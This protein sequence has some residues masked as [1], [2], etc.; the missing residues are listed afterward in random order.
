MKILGKILVA[1]IVAALAVGV[2]IYGSKQEGSSLTEE[3]AESVIIN[4]F[5]ASNKSCIADETGD[6]ADWIEL[7]NP[8]DK[9]ID[10]TGISL[11]NKQDNEIGWVFPKVILEPKGY[12]VVFATSR[13]VSNPKA[14]FQHTGFKLSASGGEI[15]LMDGANVLDQVKYT[16]QT[17]NVSAGR[18]SEDIASWVSFKKPTPGFSN[19]EA[20]AAAFAQSRI[21]EE[22]A[23]LITEVM[24]SNSTTV[25]DGFGNFND[26]IEIYNK[27]EEAIDLGGYGL[28]D[29]EDNV[30]KWH[31]PQVVIEP[32]A[33][34]I[35]FASGENVQT[36]DGELH[37][38]F[39]VSSYKETIVLSNRYGMILDKLTVQELSSDHAYA[40]EM[41]AD[42]SY[43]DGWAETNQPTPGYPNNNTGYS[44]FEKNNVVA[45]GPIVINEI[46]ISNASLLTEEDGGNYDWIELYNRSNEIVDITGYS[47]T[48]DPDYPTKWR[49]PEKTL[50]PGEY[51]TV[52]ASGLADSDDVKKKYIHTNFKLSAMGEVLVLYD[53]NVKLQD[54]YN[55]PYL[56]QGITLGRVASE[57]PLFC[58]QDPTPN[59]ANAAPLTG[60]ITAP[61][62]SVAG[63]SYDT[64][65][66]VAFSTETPDTKVYY[67]LDGTEPT[68]NSTRYSGAISVNKTGVIRARAYRDG[69]IDSPINTVTYFIGEEHSLPLV[70][71]VADPDS[72]FNKVSGIYELGPDPELVQGSTIH[73]EKANYLERGKES[74]RPASFEVFDENGQEVFN[75]NVAIRIQGGYSRDN[76][77]KSFSVI[78]RSEYGP[79]TMQYS[80]FDDRPFTEYKSIILR[81]GGQDQNIAKIKEAVTLSLVQDKGFNFLTQAF[82]PYVMYLNGEYWGVYFMMEK[83]NEFYISQHEGIDDPDS[84]NVLYASTRT[85]QGNREDYDK[86]VKY[87]KTHDMSQKESFKYVAQYIDTDSFMDEM[88]CEIWVANTDYANM[89]YYQVPGGK[90]KQIYYDFCWTFGSSKYPDGIHP[91]L[92]RR[93]DDDVCCS[94]LFG[95]LLDYK[96]WRDKFIERFAWALKE[97][98]NPERVLAA[99]DKYADLVRDEIP[100]E[101]AK[102]G[103]SVSSWEKNVENM[104]SFTKGRG[105]ELVKQMKSLFSLSQEQ[106]KMLDDAI[107]YD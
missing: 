18:D 47:L 104:R 32:G 34:M 2:F 5:M 82:K 26:Y 72:L 4:E 101:R 61:I 89:E 94:T 12:I 51:V 60:I 20:G 64:A 27:G 70:S 59:A 102:F 3:G 8:T 91:T 97:V 79:G 31:F 11:T 75:Q 74:E 88:I 38:G 1:I 6:F 76:A 66:Q 103:G 83:R 43:G 45:M 48:D 44:E 67:T 37:A 22:P 71:I 50:G 77:Q 87:I 69:Y 54:R 30:A 42:G 63:G 9:S 107:K 78:A 92:K 24:P 46:M 84:I 7:Y 33:H 49:F 81:Q 99:I 52:M 25:K 53:N 23:L 80:F 93:M 15:Y 28:S 40:R 90:Y 21:V 10:L 73:Y 58:F 68:Q 55:I 105:K 57:N 65:Q 106:I 62:P 35:V 56:P 98:Y 95:G 16:E 17:S 19:D 41:N 86:A 29:N 36:E 85:K 13:T 100:D 39:R 96:P 14:P